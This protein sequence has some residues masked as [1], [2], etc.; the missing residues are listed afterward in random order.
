MRFAWL[1]A[2]A[3]LLAGCAAAPV[4]KATE[5]K[6]VVETSTTSTTTTTTLPPTTTT[7]A[8]TQPPVTTTTFQ[9]VTVPDAVTPG[10]EEGTPDASVTVLTDAGFETQIVRGEWSDCYELALPGQQAMWNGGSVVGQVPAAGTL[11]PARSVVIIDICG[12]PPETSPP[13]SF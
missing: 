1:V 8:T 7:T 9:M 3:L 2:L 11:A 4:H 5:V 6:R 12:P 10:K 13:G